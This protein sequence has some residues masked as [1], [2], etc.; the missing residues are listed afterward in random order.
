MGCKH[1]NGRRWQR[2]T[3]GGAQIEYRPD[4]RPFSIYAEYQG[5]EQMAPYAP[6]FGGLY[7]E[8]RVLAGV[9][10]FQG[11]STLLAATANGASLTD[12]DPIY[13]VNRSIQ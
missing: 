10:F 9:R 1:R 7:L 12:F 5:L 11:G 8:N 6:A 13:G 4:G 2:A 3:F